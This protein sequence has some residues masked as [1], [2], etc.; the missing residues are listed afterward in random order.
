MKG[1]LDASLFALTRRD[2]N[3][4]HQIP[5]LG[6]TAPAA[7][8]NTLGL[9]VSGVALATT[10]AE[11]GGAVV[12]TMLLRRRKL[13]SKTPTLPVGDGTGSECV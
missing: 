6:A 7:P 8:R 12:L 3:L 10:F 9:G 4:E 1:F 13:L 11:V 5:S 2:P